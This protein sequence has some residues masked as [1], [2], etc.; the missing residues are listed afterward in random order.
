MPK[1]RHRKIRKR[2]KRPAAFSPSPSGRGIKGEGLRAASSA[3]SSPTLLPEGEGKASHSPDE[4]G[5]SYSQLRD[6]IWAMVTDHTIHFDCT[7]DEAFELAQKSWA[8]GLHATVVT[9]AAANR[10]HGPNELA[11]QPQ[12]HTDGH[13]PQ[14]YTDA[15]G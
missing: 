8:K 6:P 9:N 2:A 15:H 5:Q 3:P 1:S 7:Y 4:N 14:I 13:G 12:I 10:I 11:E